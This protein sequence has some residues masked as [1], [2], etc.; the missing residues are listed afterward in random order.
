MIHRVLFYLFKLNYWNYKFLLIIFG[1][2]IEIKIYNNMKFTT[3]NSTFFV[4]S[5]NKCK[6]PYP[7]FLFGDLTKVFHFVN[8]L[9]CCDTVHNL[10]IKRVST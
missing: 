5:N 4:N 8:L 7:D 10:I 6:L 1:I 9:D 3:Y 2:F